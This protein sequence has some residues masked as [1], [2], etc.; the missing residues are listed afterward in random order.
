ML[1]LQTASGAICRVFR[2]AAPSLHHLT[3]FLI[4]HCGC[5][6]L[7]MVLC[8]C[9]GRTS[10]MRRQRRSEA[11]TGAASLTMQST[12]SSSR[13][14]MSSVCAE[15]PG[16]RAHVQMRAGP[17][18]CLEPQCAG[19]WAEQL[20]QHSSYHWCLPRKLSVNI[21]TS[22]SSPATLQLGLVLQS[23]ILLSTTQLY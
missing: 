3:P 2:P 15:Y 22:W 21:R 11:A 6:K 18:H 8:R 12:P 19:G 14:M 17:P 7:C 9:E 4:V 16:C 10:G 13:A 5:A 1:D 23:L 20:A